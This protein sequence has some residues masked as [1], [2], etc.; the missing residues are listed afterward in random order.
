[1]YCRKCGK[2]IDYDAETCKECQEME[3]FFSTPEIEPQF[4]V[5]EQPQYAQQPVQPLPGNKKEGFGK[6]LAAT[7]L[8]GI[9]I[10]IVAIALGMLTGLQ[11]IAN[12]PYYM[13]EF[14][15]RRG[16]DPSEV[17]MVGDSLADMLFG[18]NSGAYTVGVASCTE[19]ADFIRPYADTVIHDVSGIFQVLN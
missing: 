16:F 5:R 17:V 15:R 9:A 8:G 7:I 3:T 10:F 18:R 11:D 6:A 19:N 4:E 14:C 1:M 13:Y 12:D 2:Q